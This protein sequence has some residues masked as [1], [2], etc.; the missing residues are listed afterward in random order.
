MLSWY[1]GILAKALDFV[2]NIHLFS[3]SGETLVKECAH[4]NLRNGAVAQLGE[5]HVRNVRVGGSSPICSILKC[6]AILVC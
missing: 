2:P 4:E 3:H 6:F 5:H 1:S